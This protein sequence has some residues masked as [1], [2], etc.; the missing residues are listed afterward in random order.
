MPHRWLGGREQDLD[1]GGAHAAPGIHAASHAR[2]EPS[3]SGNMIGAV[4]RDFRAHAVS[5]DV[6]VNGSESLQRLHP[7]VEG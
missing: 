3:R 6:T 2:S 5:W 4:M 7:L 1:R